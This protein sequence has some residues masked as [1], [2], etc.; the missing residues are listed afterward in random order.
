V[1]DTAVATV[2]IGDVVY[3]GGTFTQ[4]VAPN[5]QTA[6]RANLAAFCLADGSLLAAQAS[7]SEATGLTPGDAIRVSVAPAPVFAVARDEHVAEA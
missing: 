2:V 5:G 7:V 4:A 1:N 6:G 3:V